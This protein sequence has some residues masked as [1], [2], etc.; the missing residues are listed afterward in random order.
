LGWVLFA[1]LQ[2]VSGIVYVV[3]IPIGKW[4]LSEKQRIGETEASSSQPVYLMTRYGL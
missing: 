3:V 4:E 2:S 1:K